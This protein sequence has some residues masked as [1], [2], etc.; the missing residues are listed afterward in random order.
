[1]LGHLVTHRSVEE[2]H[3][4]PAAPGWLRRLFAALFGMKR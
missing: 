3:V 2:L 4:E 1:M